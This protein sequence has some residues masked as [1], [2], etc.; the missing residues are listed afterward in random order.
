[1][2]SKEQLLRIYAQHIKNLDDVED[3]TGLNEDL[4]LVTRDSVAD[5]TWTPE[6]Q[7]QIDQLDDQLVA[8]WA[9]IAE[10]LPNSNF[11]RDRGRWWWFLHEGPHVRKEAKALA[12]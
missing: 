6:Q 11:L 8:R 12:R 10:V 5:E 2:M 1:M 3:D 7:A 4:V 9:Q